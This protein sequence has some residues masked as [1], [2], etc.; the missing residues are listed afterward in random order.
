[1]PAIA[2]GSL[3]DEQYWAIIA[4]HLKESGVEH[5]PGDIDEKRAGSIPLHP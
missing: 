4:F 1:M 3:S 5:G 2:P